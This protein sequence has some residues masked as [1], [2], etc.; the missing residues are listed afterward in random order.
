M[1]DYS[2]NKLIRIYGRLISLKIGLTYIKLQI[3]NISEIDFDYILISILE[4]FDKPTHTF[5]CYES[6]G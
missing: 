5:R 2:A 6:T 1:Y 4:E 3:K